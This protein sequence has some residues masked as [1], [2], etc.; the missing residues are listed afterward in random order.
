VDVAIHL[1]QNLRNQIILIVGEG[2]FNSLYA[3]SVF[4]TQLTYPW[5]AVNSSFAELKMRLEEQTPSHASEANILHLT[6]FTGILAS[7][8]GENLTSNIL[9][10]AWGDEDE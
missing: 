10:S 1:W 2:G 5:L 4:V 6:T 3:R 8:I 9:R 7:L